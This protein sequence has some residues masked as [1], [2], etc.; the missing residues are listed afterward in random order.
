MTWLPPQNAPETVPWSSP[1]QSEAV[2]WTPPQATPH[3]ATWGRRVGATAIDL[4]LFVACFF[5]PF[6]VV[7]VIAGVIGTTQEQ[8]DRYLLPAGFVVAALLMFVLPLALM[9]RKGDANGQTLGKQAVGIRVARLDGRPVGWGTAIGRDLFGKVIL[10]ATLLWLLADALWALADDRNQA[11]HDKLAS[12]MIVPAHASDS[13]S[14]E[15][16]GANSSAGR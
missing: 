14:A 7:G 3:E 9:A 13:A 15:M 6:V 5:A 1:P 8:D 2:P 11:L 4:V 10:G 12:T 16:A